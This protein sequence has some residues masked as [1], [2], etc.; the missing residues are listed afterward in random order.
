MDS[1]CIPTI[2]NDGAVAGLSMYDLSVAG[3]IRGRFAMLK[4]DMSETDAD[5]HK[6]C[7]VFS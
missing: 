6:S 5:P 2:T 3:V 4:F 7:W 1:D